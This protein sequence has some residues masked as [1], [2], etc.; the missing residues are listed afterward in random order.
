MRPSRDRLDSCH[1]IAVMIQAP[2]AALRAAAATIAVN[3]AM[4]RARSTGTSSVLRLASIRCSCESAK[5]GRRVRS[6]ASVITVSVPARSSSP[7]GSGDTAAILAPRRPTERYTS[8]VMEWIARAR[9]NRSRCSG[10]G[11]EA[12]R[13][14]EA[15][16]GVVVMMVVFQTP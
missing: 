9:I 8:P 10:C 6:P 12:D 14:P 7:S 3:S 4:L 16:A 11:P 1:A 15:V 5:A 13:D 2:G